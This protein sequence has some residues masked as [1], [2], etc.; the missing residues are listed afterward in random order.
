MKRRIFAGL[1]AAAAVGLFVPSQ[2]RACDADKEGQ[3]CPCSRHHKAKQTDAAAP[4]GDDK[5]KADPKK[6][7]AP[8]KAKMQGSLLDPVDK[9]LVA[10]KCSCESAADCTCKKGTCKCPKCGKK[11]ELR[12]IAPI[13][14]TRDALRL[15]QG[16][17]RDATS[18]VFI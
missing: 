2:A 18:G 12:M 1:V 5:A 11:S 9:V 15:P 16:G 4:K 3:P 10:D 6:A 13:K 17:S 7:P 14:G 8:E